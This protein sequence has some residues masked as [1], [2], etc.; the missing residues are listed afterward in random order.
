MGGERYWELVEPVWDTINIYD[1][2]EIFLRTY[3]EAPRNSALLFAAHFC[4]S[5]ICNGGFAQFFSNSTGVL[6]PEALEGFRAIGQS[7]V[8]RTIEEAMRTL[9]ATYI[10]DRK[11]RQEVLKALVG[12]HQDRHRALDE[13]VFGEF[14][15]RFFKLI[16][17]EVGGFE[18]AADNFAANLRR[19]T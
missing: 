11:A 10:R 14:D 4:Q 15:R 5:E 3:G 16:R 12:V 6:A 1:G 2:P 19:E 9:G 18:V 7:E 8:A 17:T 13:V